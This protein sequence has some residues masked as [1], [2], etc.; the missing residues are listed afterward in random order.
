[1]TKEVRGLPHCISSFSFSCFFSLFFIT[2]IREGI[3]G[4]SRKLNRFLEKTL[5][6]RRLFADFSVNDPCWSLDALARNHTLKR[7]FDC[8]RHMVVSD[9]TVARVLTWVKPT[10][11]K[12]FLQSILP[13]FDEL[14]QLRW[15][16][17]PS[18]RSTISS[19]VE[20]SSSFQNAVKGSITRQVNPLLGKSCEDFRLCYI[21]NEPD[22]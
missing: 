13:R 15:F 21:Y 19:M 8:T 11:S 17:L 9:S 22:D 12:R 3:C 6:L 16:I 7:L 4:Y 1:M 10:Q 18:R 2:H 20:L 5:S 14:E